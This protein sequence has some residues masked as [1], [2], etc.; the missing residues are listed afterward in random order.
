MPD[1]ADLRWAVTI[2]MEAQEAGYRALVPRLN[3]VLAKL[4]PDLP[5]LRISVDPKRDDDSLRRAQGDF[6]LVLNDLRRAF[7]RRGVRLP[8]EDDDFC[9]WILGYFRGKGNPPT[10]VRLDWG[11]GELARALA[12]ED[13]REL[14]LSEDELR[15]NIVEPVPDFQQA[16]LRLLESLAT[17]RAKDGGS[18]AKGP[19][20][21]ERKAGHAALQQSPLA[22]ID[23]A[24]RLREAGHKRATDAAVDCWLR[25][26]ALKSRRC[27]E[28]RQNPRVR[29][30]HYLYRLTEVWGLLLAHFGDGDE[31]R[32]SDD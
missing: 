8:S 20:V 5:D 25:R 18:R 27:R 12:L 4:M 26:Y 29:E 1:S 30:P 23:I 24:R 13:L 28:E 32:P 19:T 14:N 31:R 22:A 21:N 7:R 10:Y 2:A 11:D 9:P 16:Q 3:E 6:R 17:P 15:T